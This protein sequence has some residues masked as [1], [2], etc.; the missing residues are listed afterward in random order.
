MLY[1]ACKKQDVPY[2]KTHINVILLIKD[3][4][5]STPEQ[6]PV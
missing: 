6:M 3:V 2:Y 1:M 4:I 5:N